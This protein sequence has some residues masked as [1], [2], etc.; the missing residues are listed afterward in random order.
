MRVVTRTT[1]TKRHVRRARS[2]HDAWQHLDFPL[3]H[4]QLINWCWAAIATSVAHY[5]QP[6]A[7]WTQCKVAN[8]ELGRR[9]CCSVAGHRRCNVIGHLVQSL[10]IVHH[11]AQHRRA[12]ST[13]RQT[14]RELF[15]GRPLAARVAWDGGGAHYVTIVGYQP[16]RRMLAIDD[17]YYGRSHVPYGMFCRSYRDHGVWTDSYCTKR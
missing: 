8:A 12:K 9:D 1:A 16:E 5:Y 4:Q 10:R 17:P 15:A 2:A 3:Q 13:F 14:E 11:L 6:H 7:P